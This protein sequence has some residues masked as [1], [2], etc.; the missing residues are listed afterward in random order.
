MLFR[1][2]L[3]SPCRWVEICCVSR[4]SMIAHK[5]K[6]GIVKIRFA[7]CRF[8]E[9]LKTIIRITE[10]IEFICRFKPI[11]SQRISWRDDLFKFF[12]L[13]RDHEGAVIVCSL[14]D[15]KKRLL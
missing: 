6:N 14:D 4:N 15:C 1:K 7:F 12:V 5:N 10:T 9:L 3:V 13:L 11:L 2:P 8:Y